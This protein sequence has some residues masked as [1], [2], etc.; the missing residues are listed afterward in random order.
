MFIGFK[1]EPTKKPEKPKYIIPLDV[2]S[3]PPKM[4]QKKV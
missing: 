2:P 3:P 4:E 1:S